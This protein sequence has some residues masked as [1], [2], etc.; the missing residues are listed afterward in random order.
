MKKL[1]VA[2]GVF[3]QLEELAE[4]GPVTLA[5]R[6][7]AETRKEIVKNATKKALNAVEDRLEDV[8]SKSE[9]T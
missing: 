3:K 8:S 7:K 6:E 5:A 2:P 4:A 1:V 9:Q